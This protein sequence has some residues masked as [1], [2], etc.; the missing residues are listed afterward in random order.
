M[1]WYFPWKSDVHGH[2]TM[3]FYYGAL[4]LALLLP[5][6]TS[7][8][9]PEEVDV[10]K[11]EA[12]YSSYFD[13]KYVSGHHA[14]GG[15]R[16]NKSYKSSVPKKNVET[17]DGLGIT[18]KKSIYDKKYFDY[19]PSEPEGSRSSAFQQRRSN[20]KRI[21]RSSLDGGSAPVQASPVAAIASA[22]GAHVRQ[23]LRTKR[24]PG[25]WYVQQQPA[26]PFPYPI[27]PPG[28]FALYD[29]GVR[30][31]INPFA[32]SNRQNIDSQYLPPP[33]TYLPAANPQQRPQQVPGGVGNRG[34][35]DD[36]RFIFDHV[37]DP[38]RFQYF[39]NDG[40][41]NAGSRP[42]GSG[43]AGGSTSRPVPAAPTTE[44]PSVFQRPSPAPSPPSPSPARPSITSVTTRPTS[45]PGP[46]TFNP[47]TPATSGPGAGTTGTTEGSRTT[48]APP[49]VLFHNSD[50]DYD[51][52]SLGLSN[53]LDGG[54]GN[55]L[56]GD[57]GGTNSA[58]GAEGGG[59]RKPSNCTWAIANCC[60]HNS[61]KIR[62][63]CFEQNQCFGAF[64]GEN[65]CRQYFQL[66]LKEIEN[67]YNV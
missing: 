61:D 51:W 29:Q 8:E 39:N 58:G 2:V 66:A 12:D 1:R 42:G 26:I 7:F 35:F 16:K 41:F 3:L 63:Y 11:G 6:A 33:N 44:R 5:V 30:A 46:S 40:T 37:Y 38:S 4:L 65:V 43:F 18:L 14:T 53:P 54:F 52:S 28:Q 48:T 31:P 15:S 59:R 36:Q 67:Y 32:I 50:D 62:Y 24:Q 20:S 57:S 60:S 17:D 27:Q 34:T 10:Q 13:S 21:R 45:T 9:R 47:A 55:R 56:G 49:P 19:L 23:Q 25:I 64:W 22:D